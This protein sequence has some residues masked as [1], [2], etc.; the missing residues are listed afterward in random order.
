MNRFKKLALVAFLIPMCAVAENMF[1]EPQELALLQA[2][3][4]VEGMRNYQTRD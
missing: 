3:P 1:L 2:A 4:G